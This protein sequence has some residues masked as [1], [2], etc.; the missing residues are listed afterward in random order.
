M[1]IIDILINVASGFV[2]SLG[3]VVFLYQ[4]RPKLQISS[5]ISES[6]LDG[7]PVFGFKIINRTPYKIFD[8]EAIVEIV[9]PKSVPGG[10]IYSSRRVELINER[11]FAVDKYSKKDSDANYAFRVRTTTDLKNLW[12]SESQYVRI[13]IVAR[14]ALSGFYGVFQQ[15][16]FSRAD[17]RL[18]SHEFGE[19]LTVRPLG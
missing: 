8:V 16:Y 1:T 14:H 11:F 13:T 4:L 3:V 18:G 10:Q 17:I 6:K 5:E 19:G 9:S 7:S 12:T 2:A 15:R